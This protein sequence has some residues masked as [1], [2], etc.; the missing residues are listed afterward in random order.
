MELVATSELVELAAAAVMLCAGVRWP[1]ELAKRSQSAQR[2][3][4]ERAV[5]PEREGM[6]GLHRSVLA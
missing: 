3:P 6:A 5:G 4:Q 2:E 1:L